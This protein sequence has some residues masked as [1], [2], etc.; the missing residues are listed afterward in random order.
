MSDPAVALPSPLPRLPVTLSDDFAEFWRLPTMSTPLP[1]SFTTVFMALPTSS[2]PYLSSLPCKA[3]SAPAMNFESRF[4]AEPTGAWSSGFAPPLSS[5][6]PSAFFSELPSVLR[7]PVMSEPAV[8]FSS[9]PLPATPSLPRL[10]TAEPTVACPPAPPSPVTAVPVALPVALPRL[11]S[12]VE[13]TC[14]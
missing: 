6:A 13:P 7:L 12:I 3:L 4:A 1:F 10:P 5:P 8:P 11:P 14:P 2:V 9:P